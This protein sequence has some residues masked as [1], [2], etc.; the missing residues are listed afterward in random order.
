MD[1]TSNTENLEA[2]ANTILR[3]IVFDN[4]VETGGEP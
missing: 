4:T 2:V 1:N 3:K